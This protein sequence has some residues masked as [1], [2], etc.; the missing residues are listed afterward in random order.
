M[1]TLIYRTINNID[2]AI[3]INTSRDVY[4]TEQ[5]L[6]SNDVLNSSLDQNN[7]LNMLSKSSQFTPLYLM[8]EMIDKCNFS[9]PFCYIVGHS[10]NKLIRFKNV[11][12]HLEELIENGLLYCILTG[13]EVTYHKDFLEIYSFLKGKGV[14]V[15][16][17]SNGYNVNKEIIDVFKELPPYSVEISIYGLSEP[18]FQAATN[19]KLH[20]DVVL[21]SIKELKA[22]GINVKCKTAIN[23]LTIKEIDL[24]KEWC[25]SNQ[26][27]H[28]HSSDM[29]VAYD[30][31]STRQWMADEESIVHYDAD[32]EV[33]F[34]KQFGKPATNYKK[35]CFSCSVGTYSL[36]INSNFELMPCS[37]FNSK[38]ARF[39][40]LSNGMQPSIQKML[41]YVGN[42]YHDEIIGCVGCSAAS[43]CKMCP[44][45][46]SEVFNQEDKLIGFKTNEL[47]CDSTRKKYNQINKIIT[48][49]VS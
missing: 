4:F 32:N 30:G 42:V 1:M 33:N 2:I 37:S 35:T 24:I 22:N 19:T 21:N 6:K 45:I 26:I 29:T 17:Y 40:I 7:V 23:S 16:V 14:F 31:N 27:P 34:Q 8:W 12:H 5:F 43:I 38:N 44:A 9:C 10:N 47:F 18:V 49:T 41:A 28:Y 3:D 36:Y 48:K 39:N 25:K 46:A 13:G 11:K 20:P 15:E